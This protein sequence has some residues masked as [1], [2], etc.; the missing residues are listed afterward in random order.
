MTFLFLHVWAASLFP[1]HDYHSSIT[2]VRYMPKKQSIEVVLRVFTDDLEV[3]LKK[4]LGLKSIQLENTKQH[5]GEIGVYALACLKIQNTKKQAIKGAYIGKEKDGEAMLLYMEFP[6][7]SYPTKWQLQNTILTEIYHD[8]NNIVNFFVG[9]ASQS[10][11]T[12][13]FRRDSSWESFPQ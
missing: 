6:A 1:A 4:R 9:D 2:E 7:K 5:D 11:K 13:L 8:Q 3:V 12:V 10:S